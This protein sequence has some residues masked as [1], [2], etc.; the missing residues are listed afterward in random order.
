MS[1]ASPLLLA[2]GVARKALAADMDGARLGRAGDR[3]DE[4]RVRRDPLG[5]RCLLDR[6]LQGLGQAQADP[7]RQLLADRAGA[8]ARRVDEDELGLLAREA[9]LDVAGRELRVQ[10]ERGL[11][12]QVEELQP[13]VRAEGVAEPPCDLCGAL[14]PE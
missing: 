10:L 6:R 9:N 4:P 11:G 12:E 3:A 1:S 14:V 5:V 8:L 13:Q 2:L 7:R